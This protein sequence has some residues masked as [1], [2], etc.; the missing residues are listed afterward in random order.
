MKRSYVVPM[1]WMVMYEYEVP[2]GVINLS[3]TKLLR[4]WS[5][6][7]FSPLRKNFHDRTGNR[8][9]DLMI[10]SQKL[11]PLDHEA[12]LSHN[13]LNTEIASCWWYYT[14]LLRCTVNKTLNEKVIRWS[15]SLCSLEGQSKETPSCILIKSHDK[16]YVEG[17][18]LVSNG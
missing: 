5:P 16:K 7:E 2:G 13:K 1:R 17:E 9:R 14:D 3:S 11:R 6:S 8:T 15:T 18:P 10:S 4:P 12:G